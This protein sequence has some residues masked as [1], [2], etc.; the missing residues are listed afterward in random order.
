MSRII[1]LGDVASTTASR[2]TTE[3]GGG[4][5]R[6]EPSGAIGNHDVDPVNQV[7]PLEV[8]SPAGVRTRKPDISDP[9]VD[10][11]I[12]A[13]AIETPNSRSMSRPTLVPGG[14]LCV[15]RLT[16]SA[17][18]PHSDVREGGDEC[19]QSRG[20]SRG[21]VCSC[22]HMLLW[23]RSTPCCGCHG[24]RRTFKASGFDKAA[25]RWSARPR[26]PTRRC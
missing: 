20:E 4:G 23:D 1:C 5:M 8:N 7:R 6:P 26:S 2:F 17:C 3:N 22:C 25:R 13:S 15:S 14:Y 16:H 11:R 10:M 18:S 19:G 12:A 21:S 9:R 24:T